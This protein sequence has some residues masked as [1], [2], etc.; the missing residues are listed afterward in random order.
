MLE[1]GSVIYVESI[2]Y[3]IYD[4]VYDYGSWNGKVE[5][6]SQMWMFR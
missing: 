3:G 1:Q 4:Q 2:H 6:F 5:Y